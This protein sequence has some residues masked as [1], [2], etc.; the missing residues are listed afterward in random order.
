ML[1]A[2][3]KREAL[4]RRLNLL[5]REAHDLP[6]NIDELVQRLAR[7]RRRSNEVLPNDIKRAESLIRLHDKNQEREMTKVKVNLA[8]VKVQKLQR[9]LEKLKREERR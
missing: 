5:K 1:D 6:L 4:S 2:Q 9:K 3:Q 8:K 7:M